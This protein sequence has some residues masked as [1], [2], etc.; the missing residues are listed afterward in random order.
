MYYIKIMLKANSKFDYYS[1]CVV[2]K[3]DMFSFVVVLIFFSFF[4]CK[5]SENNKIVVYYLDL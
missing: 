5:Y 3:A 4:Y 1:V 2:L